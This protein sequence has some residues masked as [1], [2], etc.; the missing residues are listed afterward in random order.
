MSKSQ[1]SLLQV[2]QHNLKNLLVHIAKAGYLFVCPS[3]ETHARVWKRQEER[4]VKDAQTLEGIFGWNFTA[5]K[6]DY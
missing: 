6:Y 1:R 2:D 5:Q 4:D 3:P